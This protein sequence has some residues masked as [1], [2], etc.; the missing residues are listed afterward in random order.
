MKSYLISKILKKA[1]EPEMKW[2][3]DIHHDAQIS[4]WKELAERYCS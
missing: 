2:D 4:N 3:K 1:S